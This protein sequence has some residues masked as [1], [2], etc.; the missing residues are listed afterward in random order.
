MT[1]KTEKAIDAVRAAI[2]HAKETKDPVAAIEAIDKFF[3][4]FV[5]HTHTYR[6][7]SG[8]PYVP[9]HRIPTSGPEMDY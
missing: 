3:A 2:D 8:D 6:Q 1:S 9:D 7:D 5:E 4:F